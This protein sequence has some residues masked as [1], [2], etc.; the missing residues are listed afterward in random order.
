M[1]RSSTSKRTKPQRRSTQCVTTVW[2]CHNA[3][4]DTSLA[5]LEGVKC[6]LRAL[7]SSTT[8]Y[9]A[10]PRQAFS[11]LITNAKTSP[12]GAGRHSLW[13]ARECVSNVYDTDTVRRPLKHRGCSSTR[14]S[15]NMTR[16]RNWVNHC[17]DYQ[18]R[19]DRGVTLSRNIIHYSVG[20]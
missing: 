14:K 10:M 3:V 5:G 11:V 8:S 17:S 13:L 1:S 6:S 12:S 18:A 16:T 4:I 2:R 7:P 20:N 9:G 15:E 19:R